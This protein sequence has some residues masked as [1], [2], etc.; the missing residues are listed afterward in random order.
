MSHP[1]QHQTAIEVLEEKIDS[2]NDDLVEAQDK[3]TALERDQAWTAHL[4]WQVDPDDDAPLPVPRIEIRLECFGPDDQDRV[5]EVHV[6]QYLIVQHIRGWLEAIPLSQSRRASTWPT[7]A[8]AVY[9]PIDTHRGAE[10]RRLN[11]FDQGSQ[12]WHNAQ[13]LGLPVFVTAHDGDHDVTYRIDGNEPGKGT[14]QV[15]VAA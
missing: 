4:D 1:Q 13:H 11:T 2:L 14:I 15:E 10:V 6:T 7:L 9:D 8:D 3:I 5:D 12:A